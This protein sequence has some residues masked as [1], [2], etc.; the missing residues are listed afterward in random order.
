[1]GFGGG[2][3]V[4][5]PKKLNFGG[6]GNNN[7]M[8]LGYMLAQ[9]KSQM[10]KQSNPEEVTIG[11]TDPIT[12]ERGINPKGALMEQGIQARGEVAKAGTKEVGEKYGMAARTIQAMRGLMGYAKNIEATFTNPITGKK[13]AGGVAEIFSKVSSPGWMP[14]EVQ[15][16]GRPLHQ[17]VAQQEETKMSMVPILSGQ[18]RYVVDLAASIAK[19]I[20]EVGKPFELKKDLIGQ[21]VRNMM[22]LTY[23]IENGIINNETLS[24][25]GIDPKEP[26]LDDKD[27]RATALMNAITLTPQQQASIEEAISDVLNSPRIGEGGMVVNEHGDASSRGSASNYSP[28]PGMQK[29]QVSNGNESDPMGLFS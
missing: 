10:G 9:Q 18:A 3:N 1:M 29:Q 12:G 27:P 14:G 8:L 6:G 28:I 2:F 16:A 4:K 13:G 21:S 15:N 11:R 26:L 7:N 24:R 23:G 19:T 25:F 5:E 17:Y 22:T 20:P